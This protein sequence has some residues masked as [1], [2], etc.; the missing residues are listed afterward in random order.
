MAKKSEPPKPVSSNVH[1][2]IASKVVWL[3]E[4]GAPDKAAAIEKIQSGGPRS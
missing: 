2:K 3:G 4:V 1:Y